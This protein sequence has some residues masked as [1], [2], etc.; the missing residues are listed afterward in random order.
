[1]T[2][3]VSAK[4]LKMTNTEQPIRG[5]FSAA[6]TPIGADG[7]VDHAAFAAHCKL[8]F[9]EGCDGVA[10]LGT[11]GEANSFSADERRDMLEKA[12]G[13]GIQPGRMMPGTGHTSIGE[14]VALTRHAVEAGVRAVLV[15]PPFYYKDVTED[16]L[17]AYFSAV[18]DGVGSDNLRVILYHIPQV[19]GVGISHALI[20]RL[21]AAYP[22]IFV[23]IKDSSADL[24]NM[25][26]TVAKFPG[27]S[28]LAGSDRFLLPVLRAGGA[29][30][31]T[32]SSNLI[33]AKLRFVF[34]HWSDEA[35][36]EE[37]AAVQA[38][39]EAWRELVISHPQV[40]AIK[41]MLAERRGYEGW[42]YV[43]PPHVKLTDEQHAKVLRRMDE[44]RG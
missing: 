23:G 41:A 27:F 3:W 5:I 13:N 37:V 10:L 21:R 36:S 38:N 18:A 43:R 39:I 29:G 15:L 1:M 44:L 8:L 20:G 12:I 2:Q 19:A 34:D 25:C 17:F 6:A 11:T 40:P 31:I 42:Q 16:G 4:G 9:E 30:S 7:A 14:T 33:A 35:R 28:V 26:A 24:A 32:A 22:S